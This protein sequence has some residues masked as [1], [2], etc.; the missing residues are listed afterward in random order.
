MLSE[1]WVSVKFG[2]DIASLIHLHVWRL[3]M[4]VV[5]HEYCS[6]LSL[7]KDDCGLCVKQTEFNWRADSSDGQHI[8]RGPLGA[9]IAVAK[10]PKNYFSIEELY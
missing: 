7:P 5:I 1:D 10:L 6:D 8:F 2:K 4:N 3:L 9:V